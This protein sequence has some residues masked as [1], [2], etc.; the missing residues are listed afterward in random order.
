M[1]PRRLTALLSVI[2][3]LPVLA[4]ESM[5]GSCDVDFTGSAPMDKFK[6]TVSAEPFVVQ[7]DEAGHAAWRVEV[8]PAKMSTKKRGRDEEMH[9][10]FRIPEFPI[11]SG[12]ARDFDLRA[13]DGTGETTVEIPFT[14][15]IIGTSR[16]MKATVTHVQKDEKSI[17]FDASFDVSL[18]AFALKAP[19]LAGLIHV[20]DR[21]PVIAHFTFS[22]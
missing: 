4:A 12:E 5:Q 7:V 9:K 14:M 2:L 19:V 11:L 17:A 6:G 3:A 10:M 18:K 21:V 20:R 15:T 13:L 22:R 8:H 16:D 1:T